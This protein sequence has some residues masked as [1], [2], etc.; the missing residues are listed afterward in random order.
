[1][2]GLYRIEPLG[3]EH[4]REDF[5]C[6]HE[7]LDRYLKQQA[8][9]EADKHVAAPFVLVHDDSSAVLGYY[10]LSASSLSTAD[11][12]PE[13]AS[14]LPRYPQLPVTLIGR[15]AVDSRLKGQGRGAFLLMDALRQ[16]F[17]HAAKVAAVA[18]VVDAKD[19]D[20]SAFYR[21]FRF[22]TLQTDSRRLYLPM[23]TVVHLMS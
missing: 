14:K 1:M 17:E 13:L 22:L 2:P 6:G 8:R 12:A 16:C 10:T 15:L 3:R 7:A 20:A 11:I 18:V 5:Q 23:K 19:D 4:Q 9:Q 21:H